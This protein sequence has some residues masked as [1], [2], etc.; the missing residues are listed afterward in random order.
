MILSGQLQILSLFS[1][2]ASAQ[3]IFCSYLSQD[4]QANICQ[5]DA[6]IKVKLA[7]TLLSHQTDCFVAEKTQV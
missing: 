1:G 7:I 3:V 4:A 5:I 6:Q 2:F